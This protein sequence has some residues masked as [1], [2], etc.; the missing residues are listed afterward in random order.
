[1]TAVFVDSS[2]I[3][4]VFTRDPLWGNRSANALVDAAD[5][6]RLV[7]N[8]IVYA[9]ASVRFSNVELLDQELPPNLFIREPI[10]YEAAFLAGKAYAEYRRRGGARRSPLP[11]FSS[12][13]TRLF[14]DIAC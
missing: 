12:A 10:P 4:D 3:L 13:R 11:D 5:S 6:A 14:P 9:E 7:I 8:P 2:V 1:M